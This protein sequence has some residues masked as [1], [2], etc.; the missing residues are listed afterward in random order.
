MNC[1][2]D[3]FFSLNHVCISYLKLIFIIGDLCTINSRLLKESF[4]CFCLCLQTVG[5]V[6]QARPFLLCSADRF[7][8]SYWISDWHWRGKGKGW[9]CATNLS[10]EKVIIWQ[11]II[12]ALKT[13]S[14]MVRKMPK[15]QST[16]RICCG[17]S[18]EKTK[19]AQLSTCRCANCFK[20]CELIHEV[21]DHW[22]VADLY[23]QKDQQSSR[24]D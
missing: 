15:Q 17:K 7:Q 18:S 22:T 16:Q 8:Y 10:F 14:D 21:Q 19:P 23:Q 13:M 1:F 6:S 11:G 12:S 5:L 4:I 24:D 9:T 2:T 20:G 3:N